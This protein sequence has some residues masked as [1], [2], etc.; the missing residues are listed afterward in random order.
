VIDGEPVGEIASAGWSDAAGRCVGLGYLHGVAAGRVHAGTPV[1]VDLW[2][3]A[4]AA[5]AWDR[6]TPR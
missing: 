2:G 1:A 4:T 6:W 5:A 3:V